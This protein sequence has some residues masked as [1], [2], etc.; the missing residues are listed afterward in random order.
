MPSM[1]RPILLLAST[2]DLEEGST[3]GVTI[4]DGRGGEFRLHK[5]KNSILRSVTYPFSQ[6]RVL[7]HPR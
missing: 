1:G 3:D 5:M 2:S 7:L 4:E 6:R